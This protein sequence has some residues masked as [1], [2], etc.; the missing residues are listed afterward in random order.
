MPVTSA[1]LRNVKEKFREVVAAYGIKNDSFGTTNSI[2]ICEGRKTPLN[3]YW[4][5]NTYQK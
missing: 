4:K 2:F 5:T 1:S 3:P